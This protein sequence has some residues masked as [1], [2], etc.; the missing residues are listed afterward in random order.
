MAVRA[1]CHDGF[2][3]KPHMARNGGVFTGL[4]AEIGNDYSDPESCALCYGPDRI[5]GVGEVHG[6]N[7]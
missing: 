3:A 4:D 7:E 2:L 6:I 5:A 1:S